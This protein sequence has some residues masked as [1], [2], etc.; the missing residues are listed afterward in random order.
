MLDRFPQSPLA[1]QARLVL[2]SCFEMEGRRAEAVAT[3]RELID[4][5]PPGEAV[6]RAQL[7]LAKLL[8]LQGEDDRALEV[9]LSCLKTYP[10]PLL[11]QKEIARVQR[12]MA[13]ARRL[14]ESP[15]AFDHGAAAHARRVAAALGSD[16][17]RGEE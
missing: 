15:D 3:Y 14:T 10:D 16:A 6:S 2:G 9:L 4:R 7:A 1:P 11:I 17:T 13:E 8:E 5:T 12:R